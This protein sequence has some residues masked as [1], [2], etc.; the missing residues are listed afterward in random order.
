M[1]TLTKVN[2]SSITNMR[3]LEAFDPFMHSFLSMVLLYLAYAN[4]IS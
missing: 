4:V 3:A 1:Y 2:V